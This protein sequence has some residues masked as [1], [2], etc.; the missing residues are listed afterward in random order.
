MSYVNSVKWAYSSLYIVSL[1][2]SS[3]SFHLL[4]YPMDPYHFSLLPVQFYGLLHFSSRVSSIETKSPR[5]NSSPK[6]V[7][8]SPPI[9]LASSTQ[10]L[11]HDKE[12]SSIVIAMVKV[13][14]VLIH[15]TITNSYQF[16]QPFVVISI[17]VH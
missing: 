16:V 4:F 2:V 10:N 3:L 12:V 8:L 6:I 15:K 9:Q 14:S 17:D 11:V 13:K 5:M 7:L 1:S